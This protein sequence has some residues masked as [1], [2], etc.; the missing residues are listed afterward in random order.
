MLHRSDEPG[1]SARVSEYGGY[2]STTN[3]RMMIVR[4]NDGAPS[5]AKPI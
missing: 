3:D 4:C 2:A 5:A 1:F